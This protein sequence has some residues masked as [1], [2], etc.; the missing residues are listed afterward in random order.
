MHGRIPIYLD[1]IANTHGC[2]QE[3]LQSK[4]LP[5]VSPAFPVDLTS[6]GKTD[7]QSMKRYFHTDIK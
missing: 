4:N 1:G 3:S 6:W 5:Y 2:T 7:D